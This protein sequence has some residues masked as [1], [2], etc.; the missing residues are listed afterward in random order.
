MFISK[1]SSSSSSWSA[2]QWRKHLL[3]G[4]TQFFLMATNLDFQSYSSSCWPSWSLRWW[5]SYLNSLL[6]SSFCRKTTLTIVPTN[7][8][9]RWSDYLLFTGVP[10]FSPSHSLY[11]DT[12]SRSPFVKKLLSSPCLRGL[13]QFISVLTWFH[14][15]FY[16]LFFLPLILP[17]RSCHSLDILPVYWPWTCLFG[18]VF[19]RLCLINTCVPASLPPP[20]SV[21]TTICVY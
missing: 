16:V 21:I 3:Q 12:I 2:S 17:T 20:I 19:H 6:S 1:P 8:H 11:R 7:I 13:C 10:Y 4:Q 5:S 18:F 9:S 14:T 15:L